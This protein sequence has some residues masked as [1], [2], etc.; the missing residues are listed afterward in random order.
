MVAKKI[1]V[2]AIAIERTVELVGTTL[3]DG[4]DSTSRK[5]ALAHVKGGD[6]HLNL[7]NGFHRHGLGSGLSAVGARTGKTE[8]IVVG[9]T[10]DEELIVAIIGTGK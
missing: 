5:A 4:V 8:Y 1:L 7:L 9:S 3:G 2:V 6:V 10:V